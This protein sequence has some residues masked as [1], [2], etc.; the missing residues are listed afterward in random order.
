MQVWEARQCC[1]M[2]FTIENVIKMVVTSMVDGG[3]A[4][5]KELYEMYNLAMTVYKVIQDPIGAALG[6]IGDG[7]ADAIGSA[8][9]GLSESLGNVVGN[10]G[11]K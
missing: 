4:Q 11:G 6:F 10:L 5:L 8:T 2:V 3:S 7:I 1:M 9:S